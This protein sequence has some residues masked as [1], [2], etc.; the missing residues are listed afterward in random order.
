M[1]DNGLPTTSLMSNAQTAVDN[2]PLVARIR[3]EIQKVENNPSL[4]S[5][6]KEAVLTSIVELL[7]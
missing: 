2:L 3:E 7:E 6:L 5:A 4:S 1:I